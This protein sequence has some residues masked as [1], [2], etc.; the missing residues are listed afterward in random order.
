MYALWLMPDETNHKAL[1]KLIRQL[2]EQYHSPLFEPHIT[3]LGKISGDETVLKDSVQTLATQLSCIQISAGRPGTENTFYKR[4]F[5]ETEPSEQLDHANQLAGKAF[6][7]EGEYTW[8]PH[9]S[10]LYSNQ[11]IR[12]K[13]LSHYGGFNLKLNSLQL[14]SAFGLPEDWRVLMSIDLDD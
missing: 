1:S 9:L 10:L 7:L 2:S 13:D 5:L 14:I 3:L 6:K 4:L 11:S 8:S 12:D